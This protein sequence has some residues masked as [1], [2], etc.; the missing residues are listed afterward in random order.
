[1]AQSTKTLTD[2]NSA[3]AA[4]RTSPV[5]FPVASFKPVDEAGHYWECVNHIEEEMNSG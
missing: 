2:A 3:E 1:M 4:N 5:E